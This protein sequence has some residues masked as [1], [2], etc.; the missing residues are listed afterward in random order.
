MKLKARGVLL[1]CS[2]FATGCALFD[3]LPVYPPG[4]SFVE[5]CSSEFSGDL[6]GDQAASKQCASEPVRRGHYS[7]RDA[8]G[9][10][11]FTIQYYCP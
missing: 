11:V 7:Q 3:P 4:T 1:L 9:R 6:G 2:A 8:A 10:E 5:S